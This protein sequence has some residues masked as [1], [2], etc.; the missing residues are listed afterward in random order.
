MYPFTCQTLLIVSSTVGQW[1]EDHLIGDLIDLITR[2]GDGTRNHVR[3]GEPGWGY[4]PWGLVRAPGEG[5]ATKAGSRHLGRLLDPLCAARPHH[6]AHREARHVL[7]LSLRVV[8][9]Y[10]LTRPGG[11]TLSLPVSRWGTPQVDKLSSR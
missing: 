7:S 8:A 9:L 3:C 11:H 5:R 10:R 2:T 1:S 4:T 6:P